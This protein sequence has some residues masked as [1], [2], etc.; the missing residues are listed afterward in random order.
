MRLRRG[1]KDLAALR[2]EMAR[3]LDAARVRSRLRLQQIAAARG[4]PRDHRT[5]ER[6][7]LLI[8]VIILLALSRCF[9]EPVFD[10]PPEK[11]EAPSPSPL[12][13]TATPQPPAQPAVPRTPVRKRPKLT[14]PPA[15]AP[16]WLDD[17]RLQVGSRSPRLAGCL[18]GTPIPGHLRWT[19]TLNR[20]TGV[21]SDHELD[22]DGELS[23]QQR[24]CLI[25][26]LSAPPYDLRKNGAET[27]P[28]R[29]SLVIEF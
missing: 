2:A 22:V 1:H 6:V 19:A 21:A 25:E 17:L 5:V 24:T 10:F 3:K 8:A 28:E 26:V 27:L 13:I 29:V 16:R 20:S 12:P 14:V 11:V 9:D 7:L 23:R 15:Q 18:T 4:K